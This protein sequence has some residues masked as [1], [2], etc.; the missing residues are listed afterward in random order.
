MDS[1]VLP[2]FMSGSNMLVGLI[3]NTDLATIKNSDDTYKAIVTFENPEMVLD[4]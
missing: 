1:Q 3:S 4:I 2:N